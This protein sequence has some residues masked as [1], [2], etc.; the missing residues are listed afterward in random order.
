MHDDCNRRKSNDDGIDI[1]KGR[2]CGKIN[3]CFMNEVA[4][5][6]NGGGKIRCGLPLNIA[7]KTW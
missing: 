5:G 1:G 2:W 3:G 7:R 4:N 6:W